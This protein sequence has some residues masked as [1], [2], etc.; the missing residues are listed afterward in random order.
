MRGVALAWNGIQPSNALAVARSIE[1]ASI[2]AWTLRE[3]G[4]F[5]LAAEYA[6]QVDDPVQR[7]RALREVG[8][9]SGNK[10][11]F[12]EAYSSLEGVSGEALAYALSDLAAASGNAAL[13]EKIDAA[14]PEARTAALL[15]LGEFQSAWQ[16]S[17][18]IGDPY[19]QGRAQAAIAAA[20]ENAEAAMQIQVALYRDLAVRDI[21]RKSSNASLVDS[22]QSPYY[23]VQALTALGKYEQAIESAEGLGDAYPLIELAGSLAEENPAGRAWIGCPDAA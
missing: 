10:K 3:L 20:W 12:D 18:A 2:R 23:R 8:A 21:I 16:A 22:I 17:L 6:R 15:R 4:K 19:E 9:A 5:D 1:D 14:H 13:V 11:L 7:A